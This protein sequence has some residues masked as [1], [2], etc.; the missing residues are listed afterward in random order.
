LLSVRHDNLLSRR[1]VA[2]AIGIS[3]LVLG[4]LTRTASLSDDGG[5]VLVGTEGNHE[6]HPLHGEVPVGEVVAPG[7][8]VVH[9]KSTVGVGHGVMVVE[10]SNELDDTDGE[11][12]EGIDVVHDANPVHEE[13]DES[14]NV[15]GGKDP[16]EGG[17]NPLDEEGDGVD[18]LSKA[19]HG[20][21]V[22]QVLVLLLAV[23]DGILEGRSVPE[24]VVVVLQP[25][26]G[27]NGGGGTEQD[28][29]AIL[30]LSPELHAVLVSAV[31]LIFIGAVQRSS[32]LCH[33]LGDEAA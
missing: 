15:G 32:V 23:G 5:K 3:V 4:G 12:T 14:V 25:V 13:P 29:G 24:V 10:E 18:V 21:A 6:G 33:T 7:N 19:P 20:V 11:E 2:G 30:L 1:N 16:D 17:G 27:L 28:P 8:L 26:E 31:Q 9:L 22:Y